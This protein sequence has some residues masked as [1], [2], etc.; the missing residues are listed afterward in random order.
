MTCTKKSIVTF[1]YL[2]VHFKVYNYR[3]FDGNTFLH[4]YLEAGL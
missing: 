2:D 3:V 4:S 1:F